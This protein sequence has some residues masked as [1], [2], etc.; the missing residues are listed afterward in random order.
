MDQEYIARVQTQEILRYIR[1]MSK[2]KGHDLGQT[3]CLKWI[4]DHAKEFRDIVDS[5]PLECINCG[6]CDQ[7]CD[8]K[9][10]PTPLNKKRIRLLRRRKKP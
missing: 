7:P 6:Y 3:G 5:V 9:T 2:R 8:G 1:I 4:E 10:C